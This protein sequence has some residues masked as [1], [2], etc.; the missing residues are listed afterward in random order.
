L[1][2]CGGGERSELPQE[3]T[4]LKHLAVLYGQY[5]RNTK[6][7]PPENIEQFKLFVRTLKPEQLK[8]VGV[9]DDVDSLFVS[10]R[11]NEPFVYRNT[12]AGKAA[13]G[14]GTVVFHEKT[15]R[16]G[17]RYVSYS[18]TQVQELD[19]QKFKELVPEAP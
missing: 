4:R 3:E 15:G 7:K 10:P 14:P 2:G 5:L 17:K 9:L 8:G 18:T 19:E 13:I 16:D 12:K 6:G 1:G 11:D